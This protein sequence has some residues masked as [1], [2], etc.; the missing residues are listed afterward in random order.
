MSDK[1]PS[2]GHSRD[3]KLWNGHSEEIGDN[4]DIN[5]Q[6]VPLDSRPEPLFKNQGKSI[7]PVNKYINNESVMETNNEV[8]TPL[9]K[10]RARDNLS[11]ESLSPE[12]R[13]I[14]QNY[15]KKQ[16]RNLFHGGNNNVSN[17]N[18]TN[19]EKKGNGDNSAYTDINMNCQNNEQ[20]ENMNSIFE[21]GNNGEDNHK[22]ASAFIKNTHK[23][24]KGMKG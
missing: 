2:E 3:K 19:N 7:I 20:M 6:Y 23:K 5:Y 24:Y 18:K 10:K 15:R 11:Q 21:E 13:E 14:I 1:P 22:I 17:Q 8:L 4:Y 12:E 16:K 9:G